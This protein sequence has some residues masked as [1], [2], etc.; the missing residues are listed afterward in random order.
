[1]TDLRFSRDRL[2]RAVA[3]SHQLWRLEK[4]RLAQI[5]SELAE[6]DASERKAIELLGTGALSPLLMERQLVMLA[7]RRVE[8]EAARAAQSARAMQFGRQAKLIEG[9]VE[10]RETDLRRATSVA[11]LRRLAGKPSVRAP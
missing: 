1:M 8:L 2:R 11:E 3:S 7:R 5:E 4:S 6:V 10:Q 9:L